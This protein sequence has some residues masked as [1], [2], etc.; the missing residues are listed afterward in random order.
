MFIYGA[1]IFVYVYALT[2]LMDGSKY[3]F[4]WEIMKTAFGLGIIYFMGDWFGASKHIAQ[5]NLILVLYFM[6]S[7]V[8]TIRLNTG[9]QNIAPSRT[10]AI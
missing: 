3:A 9:K 2:D 6:L 1:F 10:S 5:L 8:V 7:L 4:V